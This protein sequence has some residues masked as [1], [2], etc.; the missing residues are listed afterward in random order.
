[1]TTI[2]HDLRGSF[3]TLMKSPGFTSV[4]VLTL[5]LGIG[6]TTAIFSMVNA[7]LLRPLAYPKS[8]RLVYLHE[9]IPAMAEKFP[10]L[11]VNARH[12]MEWRQRCSSFES[13]TLIDP[14]S[15]NL[16]GNDEPERLEVVQASTTL[17]ETL[18]IQPAL[19]RTFAVDEEGQHR[20]AVISDGLWQRQFKGDPTAV[21]ATMT[22]DGEAYTVIGVLPA[23][24][25]FPNPN[26]LKVP[27]LMLSPQ[28]DA[29]VPKV[30]TAAERNELM[31]MFNFTVIARLKDDVTRAT[32]TAELDTI[33]AQLVEMAGESLELR[34]IV[35]PL[36]NAIVEDSQRGLLVVL[37]A[38]GSV[39]LI[40]CLNLAI[41]HLVRAERHSYESAI[42]L[43]LGA[44]RLQLLRQA[45][46]ETLL[47]SVLG[48][49]AGLMV[50]WASLGVLIRIAPTDIPRL[51]R[52]GIDANVL[53]FALALT[54]ATTLLCGLLP[55]WRTARSNPQGL[56]RAGGR[57][58][59]TS[60]GALRLRSMLVATEVSLGVVLLATAGLLSSSFVRIMRAERGFHAPTVLAAEIAPSEAKYDTQEKRRDFHARLLVHLTSA[61]GVH[62]AALASTLPLQG[63]TWVSTAWLPG[64]SRP[65]YERPI[66]N[67]RFVSA[68][69]FETMGIPLLA[70]RTFE[71]R[72]SK[73]KAAVISERLAQILW[74]SQEVVVGRR[75]LQQGEKEYEVI[76]VVKDVLAHAGQKPVSTLYR[77]YWDGA[78]TNTTVVARALGDPFS[79]TGSI[80]A[81]IRDVDVDLPI[82][83]MYTMHEVLE[84]SVSQR[85]FQMRLAS[86]FGVCALLLAML[87]I[88]G[89]VSYSVT[90]R[91]SEIGIR[92]AFGAQPVNVYVLVLRHGLIPVG[93]GLIVGI[94]VACVL[95]RFL[96]SLLYEISPHDPLT[97]LVVV[98]VVVAAA[99]AACY[100]PARRAAKIDPMEALRYE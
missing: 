57:T 100:V 41:L 88:Y 70:G 63:Q 54:G 89:V 26:P 8:D 24:F 83:R 31:G 79:I 34:A 36:K 12:F 78:P 2:W 4:T 50:A 87:G 43:A 49:T 21:G 64:D 69:Y 52:V 93:Q 39:L 55:A 53:L 97:L 17:F 37:G 42:R 60:V 5:A 9:F 22:L 19:G 96:R 40:V 94:A 48:T 7:V 35:K 65:S 75:F 38:V 98:T 77:P 56:L 45:L 82:S 32:A 14:G 18:R 99:V 71:D 90:R 6:A 59:T 25:R 15:M 30:F 68:H 27:D 47:L 51:D 95:T 20:V 81:A 62:S 74:P 10:V 80:R 28:P 91:T 3:R 67:V 44:N 76:G 84:A 23:G 33:A 16:I 13:L 1:M 86:T 92:M 66:A 85:Q 58:T 11:P 73:R 72:D 61:P 29:F 46:M